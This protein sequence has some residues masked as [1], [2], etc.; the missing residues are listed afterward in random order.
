MERIFVITNPMPQHNNSPA[1][2]LGKFVREICSAGYTPS[3]IGARLPGG[4]IP[5][6][7]DDIDTVSFRY[8]GRG[9]VKKLSYVFLQLRLFSYL[10]FKLK[11]GDAV[12]F[13]IADKMIGAF[14]A[15]RLRGSEI[16]YFLYGNIVNSHSP[17]GTENERLYGASCG[18]CVRRGSV[19]I[20]GI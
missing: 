8:G 19:S 12:Y 17:L 15:A 7:P 3:V 9:L 10:V 20:R 2:S 5:G 13:W 16:N 11:K 6:A 14:F 1:V 4:G 18:L